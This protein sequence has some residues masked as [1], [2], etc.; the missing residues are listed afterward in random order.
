MSLSPT[1]A[2]RQLLVSN[3]WDFD[4]R[5]ACMVAPCLVVDRVLCVT[6]RIDGLYLRYE[7]ALSIVQVVEASVRAPRRYSMRNHAGTKRVGLA[8]GWNG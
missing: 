4:G 8:G 7:P 6:P 1:R 5:Q 3:N 2:N